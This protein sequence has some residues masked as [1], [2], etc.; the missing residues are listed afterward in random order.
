ME[1]QA[2]HEGITEAFNNYTSEL[3]A[4]KGH[5][6]DCAE[7]EKLEDAFW[8]GVAEVKV[9]QDVTA[10]HS[11]SRV[12]FLMAYGGPTVRLTVDE[13]NHVEF[14]HSW[15]WNTSINREQTVLRPTQGG[16]RASAW[17]EVA[18]EIRESNGVA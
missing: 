9:W 18:D 13:H 17:V 15:G 3:A 10:A 7:R 8:A 5:A 16:Q 6:G 1:M 11:S 12:E 2:H 14:S 4:W